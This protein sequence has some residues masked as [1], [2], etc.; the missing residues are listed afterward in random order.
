MLQTLHKRKLSVTL[1]YTKLTHLSQNSSILEILTFSK[2]QL[3][4]ND[5]NLLPR[6]RSKSSLQASNNT[7]HVST[8]GHF[9]FPTSKTS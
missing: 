8:R 5:S 1:L 6:Y 2:P 9:L 7:L 4:Q 3:T